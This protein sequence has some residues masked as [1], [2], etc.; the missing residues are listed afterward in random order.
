MYLN[1]SWL[2]VPLLLVATLFSPITLAEKVSSPTAPPTAFLEDTHSY[3]LNSSVH[4]DRQ[5]QISVALPLTYKDSKQSYPVLYSLDAN[6]EFGTIA[7]TARLLAMKGN[8]NF[9]P[10]PE[11]IV[12]GIG[13][14]VGGYFEYGLNKYRNLDYTPTATKEE[15][16]TEANKEQKLKDLP[17]DSEIPGGGASEFLRF[18]HE[19]LI[20]D[21]ETKYRVI[22]T[23]RALFG[24]SLG[25]LF[26][27]YVLFQEQWNKLFQRL[28]ISSP[29]LWWDDKIIFQ[30]EKQYAKTH[31]ALPLPT[32][33][34]ISVA[35]NCGNPIMMFSFEKLVN[36]LKER[37]YANLEW[38]SHIFKGEDHYSVV[39]ASISRGL[40]SIYSDSE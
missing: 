6:G 20:P 18:I 5:Y 9:A 8:G 36:V 14:P 22:S 3:V 24:Y 35:T 40:R 38:E 12:V 34:F 29:S 26:A 13:Y 7:E 33:V 32:R 28:V 19:Q 37:K 17:L 39:P 10:I 30:M 1:R 4:K 16:I 21:I 2:I 25:G 27:T 15:W 23:D 11:L 31:T